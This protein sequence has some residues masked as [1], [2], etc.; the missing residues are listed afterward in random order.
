MK[1]LSV[2]TLQLMPAALGAVLAGWSAAHA[3][4]LSGTGQS[5][6]YDSAG[7][8]TDCANP[9]YPRQDA[10]GQPAYDKLDAAGNLIDAAST[11]W[12]CVRDAA[13]GLV[14][15][16]KAQSGLR[17]QAHRYAWSNTDM[18]RNGGDTG[19]T[20]EVAICGDSLNGN[21][22]TTE[23]YLAAVNATNFCGASDWRL[24][25]Q[26]ELLT[27][28]HS[29]VSQPAINPAYFPNT[30]SAVYWS[31]NTYGRDPAFAWGVNFG[32]GGANA[33]YKSRPFH[34]RLVRGTPF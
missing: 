19:G 27:L 16:T 29:G 9:G 22:C 17:D 8:V 3:A 18:T 7:T 21:G 30:A 28:L 26:R 33:D 31:A 4:T 14:W 24:P 11:E 15:E 2:F 6:C 12:S 25:S 20:F 34:V 13:T 32:Y 5:A 10:S 23:N 1:L